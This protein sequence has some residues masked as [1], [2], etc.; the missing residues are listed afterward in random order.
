MRENNNDLNN[1]VALANK[2]TN[3][4]NWLEF[5]VVTDRITDDLAIKVTDT[6]TGETFASIDY[7]GLWYVPGASRGHLNMVTLD[8]I[9]DA[10]RQGDLS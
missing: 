9:F 4:S 1:Y 5:K 6:T 8:A 3:L 7:G 10:Y 2:L